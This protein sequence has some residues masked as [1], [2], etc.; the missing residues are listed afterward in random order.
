MVLPSYFVKPG[1]DGLVSYYVRIAE[2]AGIPIM[3]Q[4]APQLTGVSMSPALWARIAESTPRLRY[5][6]A[7]GA[8]QGP[9]ISET[10]R[11]CGDRV[12]VFCGWGGLSLLDALERGAIGNMP[13]P[14]FTRFFADVQRFWESG[15]RQ[16]AEQTLRSRCPIRD[17][18]HAVDRPLGD[19][20]QSRASPPR[21]HRLGATT[22]ARSCARRHRS[23]P[24]RA[25]PRSPTREAPSDT[26]RAGRAYMP[27]AGAC[28]RRVRTDAKFLEAGVSR[29]PIVRTWLPAAPSSPGSPSLPLAPCIASSPPARRTQHRRPLPRLRPAASASDRRSR[30]CAQHGRQ[31][32]WP[33]ESRTS[34]LA[35]RP[36]GAR[37]M[38]I[39]A[40]R[41]DAGIED[42]RV[43]DG[44]MQDPSGPWV[45]AWYENLA[46]S[47]KSAMSSWPATSTIGT[48]APPFSTTLSTLAPGDE[49]VVTGDDGRTYPFAVEW[50]RQYD[51]A[52]MTAR[53][54]GRTDR[55]P[56]P[57]PDHLRRSI[58]L[59]KRSLLAADRGPRQPQPAP[60]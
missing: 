52:S 1:P 35:I 22:P 56:E 42:L 26:V 19:C 51:S 10:L 21:R 7:E 18:D 32:T 2:A 34:A 3:L 53:R 47:V 39:E 13:A 16:R 23:R 40:A 57:D 49:I 12:G 36:R 44:A 27:V 8:P 33:G 31:P 55:G 60:G 14:N 48:S 37:G 45:V 20:C 50:V 29:C 11:L 30:R 15:D 46:L 9:T 58:R 54:G 24:T 6:K 25:L 5:V 4:D 17:V 41:I 28:A 59:R 38:A 43:V